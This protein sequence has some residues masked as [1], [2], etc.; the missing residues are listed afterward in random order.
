[1]NRQVHRSWNTSPLPSA[2]LFKENKK[3]TVPWNYHMTSGLRTARC[4]RCPLQPL[5]RAM[6][7]PRHHS[8]L[9]RHCP[10]VLSLRD[11]RGLTIH[12]FGVP[13]CLHWSQVGYICECDRVTNYLIWLSDR[14]IGISWFLLMGIYAQQSQ[15][16]IVLQLKIL[17]RVNLVWRSC[18]NVVI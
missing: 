11:M 12:M 15:S 14:S 13:N 3:K 9:A 18:N 10:L 2:C 8:E 4:S 17:R 16:T 6:S 5:W 7:P 1:M